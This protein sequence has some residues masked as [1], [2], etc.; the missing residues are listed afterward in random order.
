[1]RCRFG[2]CCPR[3][4][5]A[6][7]LLLKARERNVEF[8]PGRFFYFQGVQNNTLRL[9]FTGVKESQIEPGIE[10]LGALLK[11][12]LRQRRSSERTPAEPTRVAL[13]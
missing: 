8:T 6:A 13:V 3:G 12:E 2:L 4:L 10:S 5:D 7:T 11:A 9:G 1:M